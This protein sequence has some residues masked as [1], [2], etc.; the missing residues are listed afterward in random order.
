MVEI[1]EYLTKQ[2]KEMDE[3]IFTTGAYLIP[4]QID[5][6]WVWMVSSFEDE[7]FKDGE[8]FNPPEAAESL[9]ELL[10]NTTKDD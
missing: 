7:T 6:R 3:Q 4:I 5:D 9:N 8:S 10:T 2:I 1:K